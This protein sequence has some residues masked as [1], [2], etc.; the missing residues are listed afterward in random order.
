[1]SI[2]LSFGGQNAAEEIA[3]ADLKT[4]MG[5]AAGATLLKDAPSS[6][7]LQRGQ[8]GMGIRPHWD[9]TPPAWGAL[10]TDYIGSGE[11]VAGEDALF[12]GDATYG[13]IVGFFEDFVPWYVVWPGVNNTNTNG[14]VEVA[15][16][17]GYLLNNVDW[18]WEKLGNANGQQ[19][20]GARWGDTVTE[21]SPSAATAVRLQGRRAGY[22]FND[23][24]TM[25]YVHGYGNATFSANAANVAAIVCT[26]K[27]R[28]V[29]PFGQTLDGVVEYYANVGI[30]VLPKNLTM[31]TSVAG[32]D[33]Y[34][35]NTKPLAGPGYTINCGVSKLHLLADDSTWTRVSCASLSEGN[36]NAVRSY[37]GNRYALDSVFEAYPL[38]TQPIAAL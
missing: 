14:V 27:I 12:P 8:V 32:W 21:T 1:M 23:A 4:A 15:E 16:L 30:D 17:N 3:L 6:G 34:G 5:T 28:I 13:A 7:W 25:R 20:A 26:A 33:G 37:V 24:G 38:Y 36:Q 2:L 19:N 11:P 31:S 9:A 18:T 22:K 35:A 29:P 10:L